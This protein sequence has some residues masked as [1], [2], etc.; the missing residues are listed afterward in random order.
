MR[1]IKNEKKFLYTPT[2]NKYNTMTASASAYRPIFSIEW[3]TLWKELGGEII[4]HSKQPKPSPPHN[5][6]LHLSIIPP[7]THHISI[8]KG[9]LLSKV[10]IYGHANQIIIKGSPKHKIQFTRQEFINLMNE[11]IIKIQYL[12][13]KRRQLFQLG[14][15]II[16]YQL[17]PVNCKKFIGWGFDGWEET[18]S[19]A[20]SGYEVN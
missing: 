16:K 12:Q 17:N 18:E 2:P 6:R 1:K 9:M 13:I 4:I 20:A 5:L 14:K 19:D 3:E 8:T 15:E 7:K 10:H 11:N